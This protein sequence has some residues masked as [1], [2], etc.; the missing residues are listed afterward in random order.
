MGDGTQNDHNLLR[1]TFDFT[2]PTALAS[3]SMSSYKTIIYLADLGGSITDAAFQLRA[4]IDK[5]GSS[6]E[7]GATDLVWPRGKWSL[8][9][10]EG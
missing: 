1:A 9:C 5:A 2:V 4:T 7:S 8:L 10:R 6:G 3:L